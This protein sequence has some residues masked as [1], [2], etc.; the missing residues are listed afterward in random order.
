MIK[1]IAQ[2]VYTHNKEKINNYG[3]LSGS[4]G[5]IIFLYY[6][7]LIDNTYKE[8][9][10]ELAEKLIDAVSSS[11]HYVDS[12]CNGLAGLG[13][14][15]H[16]LEENGF[17]EDSAEL[18]EDVNDY[19]ALQLDKE[20]DAGYY[21]FL[22]GAIGIGFYFLKHYKYNPGFSKAQLQKMLRFLEDTAIIDNEKNTAKWIAPN[23]YKHIK[24]STFKHAD[25]NI[26]LSHGMSSIVIFLSELIKLGVVDK[27]T[28][29]SLLNK[30]VNYIL[31]QRIDHNRY[32]C[33]FP[34]TSIESSEILSMS[35]L[36][37]CYGD[38]GIAVALWQAG[39]TLSRD[40]VSTFSVEVLEYN[41]HR[42]NVQENYVLDAGLCHGS[43]GI[44]QIFYRMHLETGSPLMKEAS[45]YW[46]DI[47]LK[48]AYHK[49]GPAGYKMYH[50]KEEGWLD[51][52]SAL[53]GIA[54]IGLS[55]LSSINP[56]WDE[57]LLLSH[58]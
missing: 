36:G 10:D 47:T 9:A 31:K 30:A 46:N 6:Y 22:H 35:R 5:E 38:L 28:T 11:S 51:S 53:E 37:W 4:I 25:F 14:G 56:D 45:D 57:I 54:G 7:S 26:S 58:K 17:I 1:E 21:D 42:R 32:G 33:Y 29:G 16:L 27:A 8:K 41:A 55:M 34:S 50:G 20:I 52:Y 15:F 2:L 23:M 44:A 48:M 18:V 13:F 19:L 12:Y 40:D 24:D 39:K 43:A 49:D 3:L